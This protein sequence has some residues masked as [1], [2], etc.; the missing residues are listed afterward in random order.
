MFDFRKAVDRFL[1][2][3]QFAKGVSAHTLRAYRFDL[4]ELADFVQEAS[5]SKQVV[6]RYLAHLYE[7]KKSV[8]TVLRRLSAL[9]SFFKFA[10]REKIVQKNP[11]EEIDSPKKE[12][13]LPVS[14]TYAQVKI[15]L[16]QPD[17]S[18]YFGFR[19]RTI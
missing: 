19:D 18:T 14:I 7:N 3:L 4:E 10:M 15:L 5:I 12:K 13:K 9:R 8:Q 2:H 1:S 6:R 17:T 16:N 11:L